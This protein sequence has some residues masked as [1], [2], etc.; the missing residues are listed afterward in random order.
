MTIN[1]LI[2]VSF[3]DPCA[4]TVFVCT[5]NTFE[6]ALYRTS[7]FTL[8]VVKLIFCFLGRNNDLAVHEHVLLSQRSA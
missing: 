6:I 4:H 8:V 2:L 7:I 5:G 1:I 3:I